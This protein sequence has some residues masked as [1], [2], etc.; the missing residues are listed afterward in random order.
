[1][2]FLLCFTLYFRAIFQV[3]APRGLILFWRGNLTEGFFALA[4]WGAY[5]WRGIYMEGLIFRNF[6]VFS[7]K[8]PIG[9]YFTKMKAEKKIQPEKV[10]V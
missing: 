1:M 5:I 10:Q 6:T 3:Q 2:P 7:L 9:S 4:V 8:F